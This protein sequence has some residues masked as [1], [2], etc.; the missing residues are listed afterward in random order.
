MPTSPG[1]KSGSPASSPEGAPLRRGGGLR[2]TRRGRGP[3]R[4]RR[5]PAR[6]E[7]GAGRAAARNARDRSPG[8]RRSR[9]PRERP[10]GYR[11][12]TRN[13]PRAPVSPARGVLVHD[14]VRP[15]Q[16]SR[17]RRPDP[18]PERPAVRL[19]APSRGERPGLPVD[20]RSPEGSDDDLV[21]QPEARRCGRGRRFLAAGA[22]RDAGPR[23]RQ[24]DGVPEDPPL[25]A[26]R[27]GA[28]SPGQVNWAAELIL[29][30]EDIHYYMSLLGGCAHRR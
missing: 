6:P 9:A 27:P 26:S 11:R 29:L 24:P 20:R 7:D 30:S 13:P 4:R 5:R 2:G 3:V 23:R 10:P 8:A 25:R 1:W 18:F 17:P 14:R 16:R 28:A 21:Q 12:R 19:P 15:S 22:R